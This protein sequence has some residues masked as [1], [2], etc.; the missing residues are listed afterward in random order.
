M[1]KNIVEPGRPQMTIWR[2]RIACWIPKATNTQSKYVMFITFALQ[3]RLHERAS[4][5]HFST[6][7]ALLLAES[8]K[9][10]TRQ[11]MGNSLS[12]FILMPLQGAVL[13]SCFQASLFPLRNDH[14]S[15][16][17]CP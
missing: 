1:W 13:V 4:L 17:V 7:A 14:L 8:V 12:H 2:M 10:S 16:C 11:L 6:V 3:Q 5:L 9:I 15:E